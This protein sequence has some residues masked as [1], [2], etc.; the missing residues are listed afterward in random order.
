MTAYSTDIRPSVR[1]TMRRLEPGVR[2]AVAKT[3]DALASEPRPSGAR[4]LTGHRPYLRVRTG[5]YR[6]IFTVDDSARTITIAVVGHRREVY[7][8]LDL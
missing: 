1:R 8:N 2:R 4:A 7:Q 6:I 5:D 3:I